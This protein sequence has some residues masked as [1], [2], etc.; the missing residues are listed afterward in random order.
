[1]DL[2]EL[3]FNRVAFWPTHVRVAILLGI[4]I[5]TL[6]LGCLFFIRPRFMH[7]SQLEKQHTDLKLRYQNAYKQ[8]SALSV[9]E[10]QL[11]GIQKSLHTVHKQF[12]TI[13]EIP[14]LIHTI[15][16]LAIANSLE[17]RSIKPAQEGIHDFYFSMPLQISVIG[18]YSHLVFF[19]RQVESLQ[20]AIVFNDFTITAFNDQKSDDFSTKLLMMNALITVYIT[21]EKI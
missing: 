16:Q 19:I 2:N 14:Q 15:S 20:K 18:D 11:V 3:S 9:Y 17:I 6:A 8:A 12:A 1:M 4:G 7:L 10:E 13:T 21:K 5:F